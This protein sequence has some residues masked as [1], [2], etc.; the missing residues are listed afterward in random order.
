MIKTKHITCSRERFL[1]NILNEDGR[2][3]GQ[4]VYA[5]V[6]KK[7]DF[8]FRVWKKDLG[9]ET[10]L[11]FLKKTKIR[12]K[13]LPKIYEH[14]IGEDFQCV[15]MEQLKNRMEFSDDFYRLYLDVFHL[16]SHPNNKTK[17]AC[18]IEE[19]DL[20]RFLDSLMSFCDNK[21]IFFDI[22]AENIMFRDNGEM[23][24]SD[25][26]VKCG[27]VFLYE[28]WLEKKRQLIY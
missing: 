25:P 27:N 5:T 12:S 22:H 13:I 11:E 8:A 9:Y 19:I 26:M 20:V 4:G 23:V 24:V 2:R 18:G 1:T 15:K 14:T 7:G 16:F 28:K 17:Y 6:Y 3:I 10:Y 21:E